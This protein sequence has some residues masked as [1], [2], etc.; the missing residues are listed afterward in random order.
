MAKKGGKKGKGKKKGVTGPLIITTAI[1]RRERLKMLCPRLGDAFTRAKH[2]DDILEDVAERILVKASARNSDTINLSCMRINQLPDLFQIAPDLKALVDI[3]LSKN[4]LFNSDQVFEVLFKLPKLL[5]VNLSNNFLNG[6]LSSIA[7][8]LTQ[9]EELHLDNNNISS[10]PPSIV[11]WKD[12]KVLTLADNLIISLPDE[13]SELTELKHLNLKN[14]KLTVLAG[15][16]FMSWTQL[17]NTLFL[18]CF[19]MI[20]MLRPAYSS[21]HIIKE[22]ILLLYTLYHY[23]MK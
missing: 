21:Y 16:L 9:L 15:M 8:R 11:G 10:L 4:N 14:N 20:E 6:A 18:H 12:L 5:R 17:G 3:N 13:A 19:I 7:G 22:N 23:F 1:I 2:V